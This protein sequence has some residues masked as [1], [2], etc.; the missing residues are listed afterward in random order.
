MDISQKDIV[1][2]LNNSWQ[3]VGHDIVAN[4]IV[5][6]CAG[7]AVEALDIEYEMNE[8]GTPN[9]DK[10]L[11]MTPVDWA[12]WITLPVRPWDL[13]IHSPSMTIRVPT[14]L[15]AKN[16]NKMPMIY[17]RG[18]PSLR[19]VY[20]RDKGIDQYTGDQ[21]NERDASIDHVI[22]KSRGGSNSWDNVVLTTKSLN[23]KKGA[24]LPEEMGLKLIRQPKK[25]IPTP[26][27]FLIKKARHRD[28]LHFMY[29]VA[30]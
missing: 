13:S 4:A 1:L 24:K 7:L 5:D 16:Y 18:K 3:P 25:P 29:P 19:A 14:V 12:R 2:K 23:Y 17:H 15:I 28:W 30:V 8:D 11:Y 20:S 27:A 21:L 9:F 26:I 22:P 10:T 6:L